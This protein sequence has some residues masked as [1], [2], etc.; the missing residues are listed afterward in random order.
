MNTGAQLALHFTQ[1]MLAA[2]RVFLT[3][4]INPIYK[5]SY[6][7]TDMS[8]RRVKSCEVNNIRQTSLLVVN[9]TPKHNHFKWLTAFSMQNIFNP[10]TRVPTNFT[11]ST[12]LKNISAES[13]LRSS[14]YYR[15]YNIKSKSYISNIQ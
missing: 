12:P 4:S 10:T 2:F 14:L 15:S 9:L 7:N 1:S 5:L 11:V 13:L 6:R 8:S 3:I